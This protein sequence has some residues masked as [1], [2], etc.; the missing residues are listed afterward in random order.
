[1]SDTNFEIKR[2]IED[3]PLT[4][5]HLLRLA[6]LHRTSL[7]DSLDKKELVNEAKDALVETLLQLA[8]W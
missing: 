3:G 6:S 1:M 4:E 5:S 7:T 8:N 2:I